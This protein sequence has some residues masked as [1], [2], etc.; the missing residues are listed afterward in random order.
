MD[1]EQRRIISNKLLQ[2]VEQRKMETG[3]ARATI[4]EHL[5]K[6][7]DTA[8]ERAAKEKALDMVDWDKLVHDIGAAKTEIDTA[9]DL[10][11]GR[12]EKVLS[13]RSETKND[14]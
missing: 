14:R 10:L 7:T 2:L 9:F 4:E 11:Y 6:D 8:E 5:F 1:K 3:R 13:E 12:Y